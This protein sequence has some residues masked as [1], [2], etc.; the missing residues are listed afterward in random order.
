VL[1]KWGCTLWK[2]VAKMFVYNILTITT[3]LLTIAIPIDIIIKK[4]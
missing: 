3:M 1:R 4:C 2:G